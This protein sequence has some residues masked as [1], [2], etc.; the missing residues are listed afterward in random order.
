MYKGC[1]VG[2]CILVLLL[3][4]YDLDFKLVDVEI[5][6][7]NIQESHFKPQK[8]IYVLYQRNLNRKKGILKNTRSVESV[9]L[10]TSDRNFYGIRQ[11]CHDSDR[12]RMPWSMANR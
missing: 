9:H 8:P 4:L 3:F 7:S 11:K 2:L 12:S 1:E 5:L 6:D 10:K